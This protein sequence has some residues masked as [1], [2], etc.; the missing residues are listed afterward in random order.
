MLVSTGFNAHVADKYDKTRLVRS[1]SLTQLDPVLIQTI[2]IECHLPGR[3]PSLAKISIQQHRH[4][5]AAPPPPCRCRWLYSIQQGGSGV[6]I[7]QVLPFT[8]CECP[9][10][11]LTRPVLQKY[12]G[13]GYLER[14]GVMHWLREID[15]SQ[16]SPQS[17][18]EH[19][20]S[21]E[22]EGLYGTAGDGVTRDVREEDDEAELWVAPELTPESFIV[23]LFICWSATFHV[24]M[25]LFRA[26]FWCMYFQSPCYPPWSRNDV[27][28]C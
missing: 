25:L 26:R 18:K 7:R 20:V 22:S 24:P 13:L 17:D 3:E 8:L 11:V 9:F 12:G 21:R 6:S 23:D 4:S 15:P 2:A 10:S 28:R 19:V 27:G 5:L 14:R 16:A 1:Q